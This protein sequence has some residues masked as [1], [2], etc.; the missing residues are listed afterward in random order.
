MVLGIFEGKGPFS[1]GAE[2]VTCS[3]PKMPRLHLLNSRAFIVDSLDEGI[4]LDVL[5][6]VKVVCVSGDVTQH[7][8]LV[9]EVFGDRRW[10]WK[11]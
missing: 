1:S 7:L 4:E 9:G 3:A 5:E 6:Q 10:P 8:M 2:R 11:I